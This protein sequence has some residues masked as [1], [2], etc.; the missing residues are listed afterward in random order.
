[1]GAV[2]AGATN[3]RLIA[4][5]LATFGAAHAAAAPLRVGA[6]Q[7]Y[8]TPCD[9][10]GAANPDDVIEVDP[11]TYTDSCAI[12]VSGVTLRG[13][14]GQPKIDVSGTD[15]PAQDKG[16]YVVTAA[17]VTLENLELTGAHITPDNGSNAAGIRI[18]APDLTVRACNIHDNQNGILG[19]TTGTITIEHSEFFHNGLGDGCNEGG[20]THN[21]YIADVDAL[22]FRFNW[23]HAIATDTPDKG[24]LLKSRAK[25]NYIEY[26]RLSGEDGFD[27]YEID[28]PNGGLAVIVGNA[29]EKGEASGNSNMLIW[30]EE[31][32]SNPDMRVFVVNNTFV[33]DR[34]SGT[35][36]SANG[37]MLTAHNNLFVGGGT[38]SS[39]GALSADNLSGVD[40]KL[41]DRS[42]YDYHLMEGSPAIGKAVAL[43]PVDAIA[44]A[45]T[46]EYVHPLGEAMRES[47]LDVGA[48][49]FGTNTSAGA[50]SD[51]GAMNV[52]G[53]SATPAVDGGAASGG[54]G[55]HAGGSSGS[56]GD[57]GEAGAHAPASRDGGV[58]AEPDGQV[59]GGSSAPGDSSSS[60]CGCTLI[61]ARD[62]ATAGPAWLGAVAFASLASYRRRRARARGVE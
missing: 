25:Q 19:G 57:A 30:G 50:G 37:A 61:G 39:G 20:C 60:G 9:A 58:A 40:P 46:S 52:D 13:V 53:G 41:V 35:F 34:A 2:R 26:N 44:L 10:L 15:H 17:G 11:G 42:H 5:A 27:S 31:G 3:T 45:A 47:A 32:A 59:E 62:R 28:L 51:A 12:D 16:I 29:I 54:A 56:R 33:N 8:A 18:E 7:A 22:Y 4:F 49:E 1:M 21:L 24:H 14:G 43:M 55:V 36:I 48:F 6:G 38:P 23:S